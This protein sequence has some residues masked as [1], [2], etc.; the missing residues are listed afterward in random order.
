MA[1]NLCHQ[2]TPMHTSPAPLNI[3]D[4]ILEDMNE[5]S[6]GVGEGDW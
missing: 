1:E 6:S 4:I 3:I 5:S 2:L